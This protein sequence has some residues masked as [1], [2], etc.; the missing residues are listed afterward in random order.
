MKPSKFVTEFF[1]QPCENIQGIEIK[2][3]YHEAD[4]LM[5]MEVH[6]PAGVELGKHVHNYSH[7]SFLA[8]GKVYLLVEGEKVIELEA[9]FCLNIKKNK[10]HSI[11]AITDAVWFCTH[12]TDERLI[13]D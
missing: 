3:F 1:D 4:G 8:K 7:L 10:Q 6:I 13:E 12:A 11:Q 2:K 9:P 5:S